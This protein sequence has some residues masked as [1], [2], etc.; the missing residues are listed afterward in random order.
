MKGFFEYITEI[1]E[2]P[3]P[4]TGRRSI[5]SGI[6]TASKVYEAKV[7]GGVLAVEISKLSHEAWSVDF[8]V[9][10]D[11]DLTGYGEP[12]K[13]LS[14][15]FEAMKEFI[16]EYSEWWDE[17]PVEFQM[18]ANK[19][20]GSRTSVYKALVR[21]FGGEYGYKVKTVKEWNPFPNM[22]DGVKFDIIVVRRD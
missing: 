10:G 12:T 7:K 20:E 21:R 4:I 9:N 6:A 5:G 15:V 8:T 2:R 11:Y 17:M 19:A 22:E 16:K 18:K 13:V 1:F 14:T 3:Y